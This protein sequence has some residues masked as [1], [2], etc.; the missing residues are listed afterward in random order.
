MYKLK[1]YTLSIEEKNKLKT[2][3]YQTEYGKKINKL[4]IRL[5]IIGIIGLLFSIYLLITHVNIWDLITGIMLLIASIIFIIA[6]FK[7]RINK[8]ND[9]LIKKKK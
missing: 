2:S 5:L 1:Y 7:L 3:F 8:L 4:L 6:S 9:H